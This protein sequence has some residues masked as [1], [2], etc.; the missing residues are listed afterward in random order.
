MAPEF[1]K[2]D[3]LEVIRPNQVRLKQGLWDRLRRIAATEEKSLNEVVS[4]FLTWAC[5]DY[6]AAHARKKKP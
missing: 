2:P 5:D 1:P 6:D 4:F 3:P